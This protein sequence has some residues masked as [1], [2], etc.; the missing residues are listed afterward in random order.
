VVLAQEMLFA[1]VPATP[2]AELQT[3]LPRLVEV[4]TST[5]TSTLTAS[6]QVVGEPGETDAT[7]AL[8][9]ELIRQ[10]HTQRLVATNSATSVEDAPPEPDEIETTLRLPH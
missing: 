2:A 3:V 9:H 6:Q 8:P 4:E 1:D 5:A 7:I 10:K